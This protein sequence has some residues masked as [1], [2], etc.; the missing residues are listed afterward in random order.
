MEY[1]PIIS[2]GWTWVMQLVTVVVLFLILKKFFFEKVRNFMTNREDSVKEAF[3]NAEIINRRADEKMENYNRR[4]AKIES[5]GRDIIK[6]AKQRAEQRADEI[7]SQARDT[8]GEMICSAEREIEREK[9]KALAEMR[10]EVVALALLAAG[11]IMEKDLE[12]SKEQERII[13]R[14]IE[15]AGNRE[16]QS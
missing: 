8:A 6:S 11:K 5:E 14:V 12:G 16:W 7:I 15:E 13:N 10:S 9:T 2:F 1:T 3:D 4:I